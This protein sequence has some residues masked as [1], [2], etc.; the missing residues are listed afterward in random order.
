[1]AYFTVQE[2]P[3]EEIADN[4]RT[5]IASGGK[6]RLL[7]NKKLDSHFKNLDGV[8]RHIETIEDRYKRLDYHRVKHAIAAEKKRIGILNL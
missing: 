3:V 6:Y 2:D 4:C 7:V 1:L 8:L 5:F